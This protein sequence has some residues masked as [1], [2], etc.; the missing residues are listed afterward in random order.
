MLI[1]GVNGKI[2]VLVFIAIADKISGKGK[3]IHNLTK[4]ESWIFVFAKF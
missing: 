1:S 3:Q 2:Q 4:A